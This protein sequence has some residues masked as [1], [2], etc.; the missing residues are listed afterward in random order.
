MSSAH[1]ARCVDSTRA[2]RWPFL[3]TAVAVVAAT[4]VSV[5]LIVFSPPAYAVSYSSQEI[6]LVNLVNDY[7]ESLGLEPLMVS[8]LASDAAEKHSSDMGKYSFFSHTT[9]E[10]DWFPYGAR[11]D[12]RLA[13]CGYSYQVAWGENIAGG[14]S[15]AEDVVAAWKASPDH[16]TIMTGSAY[17]EVGVGL[18]H[19]PD[20]PYGYYW[21]LDFGAYVDSTAH[22][23][24]SDVP[25]TTTTSST[26]ATTTTLPTI[27]TTTTS[28][29]TTTSTS[30]P[31]AMFSDIPPTNI[32]YAEISDLAQAGI[33]CGGS[34]GLF[35]PDNRVTRAQFAK[36]VILALGRHTAA[37]D[38]AGDPSFTDVPFR[39]TEYPFDYVEEA[40]ALHIIEG[41]QDGAF[42]PQADV[43][44]AQLA[45]ML[46]RAGGSGL[47]VP[48]AGYPCPFL[49]VP[50]YAGE[51][52]R[53]AVFNDLING[54]TATIFD[55]YVQAT[56]G[57][58]AKMV[59]RLRQTLGF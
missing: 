38:N 52:V 9:M 46:T 15:S 18:V 48:P 16:N 34:D 8:D 57:Q 3:M 45:L 40:A 37:I 7:R 29:S 20:S 31:G 28:S 33:V 42:W 56:R 32:F 1:L 47:A 58:V 12:T 35:H 59:Y 6:E 13:L 25:T 4:L 10:S 21:T 44:R 55:P 5:S 19:V 17:R 26:S 41:F 53:A 23:V 11:V 49:D 24:G 27:T 30:V 50:Q 39:G 22:W 36:I 2:R 54:K 51:A 43:T 14:V